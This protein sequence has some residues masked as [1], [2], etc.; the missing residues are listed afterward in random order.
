MVFNQHKLTYVRFLSFSTASWGISST[1]TKT[2]S[3]SSRGRAWTNATWRWLRWTN[4]SVSSGIGCGRRRQRCSKKRTC[5]WVLLR[6]NSMKQYTHNLIQNP[7]V[8]H[9]VFCKHCSF[10]FDCY[11]KKWWTLLL[12]RA[13]PSGQIIK[14]DVC[15]S[16]YILKPQIPQHSELA[17]TNVSYLLCGGKTSNPPPSLSVKGVHSY[18]SVFHSF[19]PLSEIAGGDWS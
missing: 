3:Y 13:P 10:S 18:Q 9:L 2:L 16:L 4:G 8:C 11:A 15:V 7:L 17:H 19:I 12:I 5:L 6:H 1:R 14:K